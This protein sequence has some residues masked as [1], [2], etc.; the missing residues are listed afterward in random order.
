LPDA[1]PSLKNGVLA[2]FSWS[3]ARFSFNTEAPVTL[4]ATFPV[5]YNYP[6]NSST[7]LAALQKGM[8]FQATITYAGDDPGLKWLLGTE[9]IAVS[10]A[11]EWD[12][13][14]PRFDIASATFGTRTLGPFSLPVVLHFVG[15]L[16]E[17]PA[18]ARTPAQIVPISFIVLEGTLGLPAGA[19]PLRIPFAIEISS[20]PAGQV[21]VLGQFAEASALALDDAAGLLGVSNL[22]TQQPPSVLPPL[23]GLA[24]QTVALTVDTARSQLLTA[25]ATVAFT[26]P[27][28]PW[29]P[30]GSD[31]LTFD[32]LAVTFYV[33]GPFS[34]PTFSTTIAATAGLAGG[35]LEA[36]VNLPGL[37]FC[38]D[39]KEGSLPINLTTLL[40]KATG[41]AFGNS[42][43]ILCTQLRVLGNPTQKIL[44]LPGHHKRQQHVGVRGVR[45]EIW[46]QQRRIRSHVPYRR[47]RQHCRQGRR[48]N[49]CGERSGANLGRISRRR[50]GLDL[51]RWNPRAA[52]HLSD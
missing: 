16:V 13:S 33:I 6:A 17:I 9:P 4:P 22:D 30:F 21:T 24:L 38:C 11:I 20:Q 32:G 50:C 48:A 5:P 2:G 3:D 45:W 40:A 7:V 10:G 35:M 18:S 8:S 46:P 23:S 29:A 27:G 25:S 1:L 31:L 12:G 39:L 42:F 43:Q 26:P 51:Q 19:R 37:D 34:S 36:D 28:G 14:Q 47:R 44:S 52:K 41:N 15:L 49:H